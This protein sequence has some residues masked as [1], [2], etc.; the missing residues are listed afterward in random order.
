MAIWRRAQRLGA[1]A[2]A[3]GA[4]ALPSTPH[5]EV[6]L[7]EFAEGVIE[8]GGRAHL[9]RATPDDVGLE[10]DLV[11]ALVKSVSGDY[12]ELIS[13]ANLAMSNPSR[14]LLRRL[15]RRLSQI[16]ARDHFDLEARRRACRAIQR[17]T[18]K[19]DALAVSRRA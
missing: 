10:R 13:D 16:E 5:G 17:L 15:E 3:E 2:L 6:A 9:W 4:I 7:K 18:D 8:G 19:V 14:R 1:V 12:L 11:D